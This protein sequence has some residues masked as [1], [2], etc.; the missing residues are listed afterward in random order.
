MADEY[1]AMRE[2][3]MRLTVKELRGIARDEGI[4]LGYAG[5]N[6]RSMVGEI[7]GQRRYRR[8]NREAS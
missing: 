8:L 1:E 4:C 2:S 6:K 7:V 5:A 3:L